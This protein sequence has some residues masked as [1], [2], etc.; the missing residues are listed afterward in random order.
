MP[1]GLVMLTCTRSTSAP[2]SANAIAIA[3]PIPRVPPVTRAVFPSREKSCWTE[4]I[5]PG[6][7]SRC[8]LTCCILLL[9]I[10]YVVVM[11][12]QEEALHTLLSPTKHGRLLLREQSPNHRNLASIETAPSA[13]PKPSCRLLSSSRHLLQACSSLAPLIRHPSEPTW[14]PKSKPPSCTASKTSES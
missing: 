9:A 11:M 10:D 4:F 8:S 12:R 1:N 6:V 7:L 13:S 14:P 3:W 5:L 2:A